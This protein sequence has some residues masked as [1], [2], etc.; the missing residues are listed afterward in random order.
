LE[1]PVNNFFR[2][3]F[4]LC[5]TLFAASSVY[6]QTLPLQIIPQ[7]K[8][9]AATEDNF[10]LKNNRKITL[11]NPRSAADRFAALDFIEDARATA[12]VD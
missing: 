8:E 1:K 5:L 11:A 4:L 12:N 2:H 10:L 9:A 6:A 7:P 3:F